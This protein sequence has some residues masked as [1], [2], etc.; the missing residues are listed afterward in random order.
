VFVGVNDPVG[1]GLVANLARPGGNLTGTLLNEESVV[2][3][4]LAM[5]KEIAPNID[6]IAVLFDHKNSFF[7]ST[8][9]QHAETAARTLAVKLVLSAFASDSD[10]ERALAEF[11]RGPNGGLLVPPDLQ[12]VLHRDLIIR[13]AGVCKTR[14]Q[15]TNM[16]NYIFRYP[17]HLMHAWRMLSTRL[18]RQQSIF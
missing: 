7:Q 9:G 12:A 8:Y 4:W 6:R 11:A 15:R 14:V 17:Y 3:K 18:R 2:S 10:I 16:Q 5:L 13:L 1:S